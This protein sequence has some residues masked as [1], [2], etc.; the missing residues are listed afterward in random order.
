MPA[1][2]R[3]GCRCGAVRYE[4]TSEP[5]FTGHCHCRDC[6][7]ASGGPFATVALVPPAALRILQ[8]EVRSFDVKGESG[9]TVSRKFCPTCGTPLFSQL[10]GNAPF[11]AIKAGSLDDPSWL[12]PAM[13]IWTDSAQPWSPHGEGLPRVPKNPGPA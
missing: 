10:S 6:Q 2:F 9:N 7:Y 1:P 13:E 4:C 12:R 8:G 11:V 3:G 5:V